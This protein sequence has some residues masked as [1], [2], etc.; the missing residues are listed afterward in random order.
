MKGSN[1][2][3][4]KPFKTVT[5]LFLILFFSLSNK[6]Q[7]LS[8]QNGIC[9]SNVDWKISG[10]GS[11]VG[12]SESKPLIGYSF[13]TGLD[14]WNKKYFQLSSNLG[15]LQKGWKTEHTL[16]NHFG[17]VMGTETIKTK[18]NYVSINSLLNFKIPINDKIRPFIG[19]GP[20]F[21]YLFFSDADFDF[22][23]QTNSL[24]KTSY[25]LISGVGITFN[26]SIIQLGLRA[27]YYTNFNTLVDWKNESAGLSQNATIRNITINFMFGLKLR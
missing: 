3:Q 15:V 25:G 6:A 5:L 24:S 4:N 11:N 2:K 20:R 23:S 7:T 16:T 10:Y 8:V 9:V 1:L 21:D 22:Y 13:F 19:I 27:D 18:L 26:F 14:Y 12:V 17:T